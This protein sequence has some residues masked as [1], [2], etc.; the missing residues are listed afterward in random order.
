MGFEVETM[1][2]NL[3]EVKFEGDTCSFPDNP[4][5]QPVLEDALNELLFTYSVEWKE[6][7]VSWASRWDIYLGMNNVQIHWFSIINSLVVVFFL[8]GILTMIMVRTLRRDIARYNTDGDNYED[9]LEETG[10]KLVHGD[11]FRPPKHPRLFAAL[12]GSGIQIFFMAMITICEWFERFYWTDIVI[13]FFSN[14]QSLPCW[15]CCRR[16]REVR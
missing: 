16:V 3:K 7:T 10:W 8:S 12:I 11:V 5:P 15:G 2:V 14:F 9:T 6:S 1:S 4:K 13:L